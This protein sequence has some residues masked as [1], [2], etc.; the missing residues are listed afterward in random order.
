M[1]KKMN[2]L[3][4]FDDFSSYNENNRIDLNNMETFESFQQ[5]EEGMVNDFLKKLGFGTLTDEE[6]I[7]KFKKLDLDKVKNDINKS[8]NPKAHMRNW[9]SLEGKDELG[10]ARFILFM[11]QKRSDLRT[12]TPLYYKIDQ[13]GT[14]D[15]SIRTAD[16]PAGT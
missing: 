1:N 2:N 11:H 15:T 5:L 3:L 13:F 14:S 8:S 12:G 7:E 9:K 6:T 4:K 16:T 10:F